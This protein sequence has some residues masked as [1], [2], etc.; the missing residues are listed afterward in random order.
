MH[1]ELEK[2][3]RERAVELGKSGNPEALPELI[4]L[5]RSP[6]ASVRKLAASAIGK[7]ADLAGGQVAVR[8]LQSMLRD[9]FPQVRQYVAKAISTYG[10]D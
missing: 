7:L 2:Q 6:A 9:H 4:E 3:Y 10:T 1:R 5:T 8:V